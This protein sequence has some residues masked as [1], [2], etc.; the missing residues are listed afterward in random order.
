MS[1]ERNEISD[2]ISLAYMSKMPYTSLGISSMQIICMSAFCLKITIRPASCVWSNQ[3]KN[4]VYAMQQDVR[5][6]VYAILSFGHVS[7]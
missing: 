1:D 2:H 5:K 3:Q 7:Q 6:L 4:L